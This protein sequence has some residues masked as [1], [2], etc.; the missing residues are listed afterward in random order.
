[1]IAIHSETDLET[2]METKRRKKYSMFD[3]YTI[4]LVGA[5][6]KPTYVAYFY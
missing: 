1:M 3:Y 4:E 5:I 6:Y 2:T